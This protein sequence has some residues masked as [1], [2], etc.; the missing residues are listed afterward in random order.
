MRLP[1]IADKIITAFTLLLFLTLAVPAFAGVPTN[2]VLNKSVVLTLN[3]PA[4]RVAVTAPT[5]ADFVQVSPTEVLINGIA[6]G[7]TTLLV[8]EQ[9]AKKAS[10]FDINVVGDNSLLELQ[11]KEIAPNDSVS[12][13]FAKDTIVLSG[14][15]AN[16]QTVINLVQVAQAYAPKVLNQIKIDDPQQVLL[17]VKVAQ[18][19]KS[20]LKK[21]GISFLVKGKSAEGFSNLVGSPSSTSQ[22]SSTGI[23]GTTPGLG[24]FNPL[25]NFQLGVSYFP[26]G[27]GAV[28]Q[29]LT[30]KNLA[31][32]LAEPNLLV[33]SGQ[34]GDFLAGSKIP[35]NVITFTGGG[36]TPSIYFQDVGIKLKFKPVVMEN[37]LINLKIDPAE[38]SSTSGTL[39]VNGYPIIDTRAV[40]TSVELKDGESLILAGLLQ[41]D[42]VKTMSKIPL[43][44]DIPILGALFRSSQD[45]LTEKELVFFITPKI[46]K[47][48]TAGA[49]P[50]LPTDKPWTAEQEK[51][52]KWIPTVK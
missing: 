49:K 30:T 51:E 8:W 50:E 20:N 44:G 40:R 45:D 15:A 19:D 29:A 17:Q 22:G 12:A 14:N 34:E 3:K 16:E 42:T 13:S 5:I 24:S 41:E 28:L 21:L 37:N 32:V 18:V 6:I 1:I 43:L 48:F 11:L 9:G 39:S 4:E 31:K 47:P 35:Y 25:D 36:A 23:S 27:V 26:G 2:V 10:F 46:V 33:K 7:S 38:V 52:L